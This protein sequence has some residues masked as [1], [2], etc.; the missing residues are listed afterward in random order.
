MSARLL[1]P[2]S[3]GLARLAVGDRIQTGTCTVTAG[4]I[5]S[6]SDLTGDRFA[7]H[8]DAD[9]AAEYGFAGR[10]AHGLLVLSLVDGL[11][12]QAPAQFDAIASLGWDWSFLAPVHAG[13]TIQAAI[14]VKGLRETSKPD[15][16]IV[17]LEVTVTNQDGATVQRGT[18]SLMV[19]R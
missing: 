17:M 9:A 16:G 6:F 13:D 7:I 5:D 15:R 4:M 10:V 19:R 3:Y 12:N 1:G 14:D 2:G 8:M 18:N 11:K